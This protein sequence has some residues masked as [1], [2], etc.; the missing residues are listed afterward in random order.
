MGRPFCTLSKKSNSALQTPNSLQSEFVSNPRAF[1]SLSRV[2]SSLP[3]ASPSHTDV[4]FPSSDVF[5][6]DICCTGKSQEVGPHLPYMFESLGR[7]SDTSPLFPHFQF[8]C[9]HSRP[10]QRPMTRGNAGEP[11]AVAGRRFQPP[12]FARNCPLASSSTPQC[13]PVGA[14]PFRPTLWSENGELRQPN[15]EEVGGPPQSTISHTEGVVGFVG[16]LTCFPDPLQHFL[17]RP[18]GEIGH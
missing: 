13:F 3:E 14:T 17:L 8:A 5:S 7:F 9:R 6:G 11:P 15:E 18:D 2:C 4:V 12:S 10:A 1:P 16:M